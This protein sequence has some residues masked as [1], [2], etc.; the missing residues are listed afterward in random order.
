MTD[1][2]LHIISETNTTITLGWTP[3]A[4]CRGYVFNAN[5]KRSST[6]DPTRSTV[7]FAK[8]GPYHVDALGTLAT[9]DYPPVTPP[10]PHPPSGWPASY[11]AGPLGA[12]NIL[13]ATGKTLLIENWGQ[14]GK[15]WSDEQAAIQARETFIGRKFDGIHI[16]YWA[17]GSYLGV[18]GIDGAD[19]NRHAEQW[20]HDRGQFPCITWAPPVNIAQVNLGAADAVFGVAADLW[21]AMPFTIMLRPFWEFDNTAGFPWSCGQSASI[22]APFVA[23]WKRMVG[24]FKTRG[25]NNVGFW[26]TPLEG[27][28]DRAGINASYPG[29]AYVDWVGSDVYNAGDGNWNTPLHAGWASFADCALY[30]NP[31]G[32]SQHSLWS[33]RK[34]FVIGE[35]GCTK[36]ATRQ[37]DWYRAIPAALKT[38]PNLC[39]L[40]FFDQDVSGL[41]GGTSNWFVDSSADAYAGFKQMALAL[42]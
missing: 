18:A 6:L 33:S 4:A 16:Q 29:D 28:P 3:P 37:G 14:P 1:L 8:P 41:E 13:P 30:P 40:S 38:A 36:D 31:P 34:P 23:A 17:G 7:K 11:T 15:Q 10:P 25:A 24:I 5:G 22:G 21:K 2:P 12:N 39:G 42:A 9:G 35:L 26:W 19:V 32:A 27:S 20:I